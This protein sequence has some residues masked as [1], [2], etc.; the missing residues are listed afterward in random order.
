MVEIKHELDVKDLPT[1][2]RVIQD[3]FTSSAHGYSGENAL[4][5]AL[6]ESDKT[7]TYDVVASDDGAIVGYAL[8]SDALILDEGVPQASGLVLAPLA[9]A[10]DAQKQGVGKALMAEIESVAGTHGYSF[11]SIL[12]GNYYQQFGYRPASQFG[13]KAPMEVPDEYFQIKPMREGSLTD[14]QGTLKYAPEFG[15]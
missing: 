14:V 10:P 4:V 15:L 11:I 7:S 6:R 5:Q 9:V 2:Q 8:L 3:A 13:I 12:G 1:L